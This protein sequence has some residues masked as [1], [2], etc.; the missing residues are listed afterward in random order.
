LTGGIATGK[1]TV[2]AIFEKRG[3]IIFDFDVV[4]HEVVEPDTPAWKDIVAYFGESILNDDRSLDR[5]RLGDIVF[6][7]PAERKKL[8][9]FIYP[10]L[11]EEYSRRIR[12]IEKNNPQALVLADT[13]LLFEAKLEGMFDKIVVVYATREQQMQRLTDRDD[14]DRDAVLARLD[15]QM[16]TEEKVERA[17]YV[18]HNCDSIE[19]V[20]RDANELFD[21]LQKMAL[22]NPHSC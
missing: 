13:P 14:L 9:G 5:A 11:F 12:E 16:P 3:A 1:S 18:I 22:S 17:D 15:A 20:E 19:D 7:D 21:E 6:P 4:A 2:T 10:R 8:E